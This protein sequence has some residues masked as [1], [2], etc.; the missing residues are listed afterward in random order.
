MIDINK[1]A[2]VAVRQTLEA[3]FS[4]EPLKP[5]TFPDADG[6]GQ[7]LIYQNGDKKDVVLDTHQSQ[8]NRIEPVFEGSGLIPDNVVRVSETTVPLTKVGHRLADACVRFSNQASVVASVLDAFAKGDAVPLAKTAPTALLF[9]LWDSRGT[10]VKVTRIFN[11]E[12]RAH[13]VS[14]VPTA[15]QFVSS[16]PRLE[17]HVTKDLSAE[18]LLD[19]PYSAK[20]GVLV[21]GEIVR[22]ARLNVRGIRKLTGDALQ[23]YVLG[24]GLFALL[25]PVSGDLREGCNLVTTKTTVNLVNENGT[26]E[27][28][29]LTFEDVKQF[30]LAAAQTFGVGSAMTFV[31]DEANAK[32]KASGKA[33]AKEAKAKEKKIG[34]AKAELTTA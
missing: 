26:R 19:C 15:G 24:L 1:V 27:D 11:S 4:D 5:S 6:V 18:G 28:I 17:D 25:Y 29:T 13:D 14:E 7:Y 16:V 2:V 30:A 21:H 3:A 34:K 8:A 20:G 9:G 22:T 10:G 31:Y 33:D 23:Q 32:A 12:I